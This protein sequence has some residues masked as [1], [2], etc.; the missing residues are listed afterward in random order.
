MYDYLKCFRIAK[1]VAALLPS[2]GLGKTEASSLLKDLLDL[3]LSAR[4]SQL[5]P[6]AIQ[7]CCQCLCRPPLLFES[8]KRNLVLAHYYSKQLEIAL[9]EPQDAWDR[10][11][12][13]RVLRLL[14]DMS[15]VEDLEFEEQGVSCDKRSPHNAVAAGLAQEGHTKY[16]A[17]DP[18]QDSMVNFCATNRYHHH[19]TPTVV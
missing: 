15:H 1:S 13:D 6:D 10:L 9:G 16:V 4:A 11:L 5:L 2:A 14:R 12:K 8:P 3:F 7:Q 18:T 19:F 17:T